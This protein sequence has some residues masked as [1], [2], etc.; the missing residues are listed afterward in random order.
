MYTIIVVIIIITMLIITVYAY[1]IEGDGDPVGERPA[2]L[3]LLHG[4]VP[5]AP[6][7]LQ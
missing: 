2:P 4:G 7:A 6:A 5:E 3:P 1:Y